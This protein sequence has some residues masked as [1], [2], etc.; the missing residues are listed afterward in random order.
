MSARSDIEIAV[1][2]AARELRLRSTPRMRTSGDAGSERERLPKPV[3]PG[4]TY[5]NAGVIGWL[6]ARVGG[7]R[8]GR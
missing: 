3:E 2:V 7:V 1:R 6:R 5:R 4:R 8:A